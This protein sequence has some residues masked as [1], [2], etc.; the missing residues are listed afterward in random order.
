MPVGFNPRIQNWMNSSNA[1]GSGTGNE[2][3]AAALGQLGTGA[4]NAMSTL[5]LL[6]MFGMGGGQNTTPQVS[7]GLPFGGES[8]SAPIQGPVPYKTLPQQTIPRT[9]TFQR[10]LMAPPSGMN[11]PIGYGQPQ[12]VFQNIRPR[13]RAPAAVPNYATS[14]TF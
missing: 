4:G 10:G 5:P 12:G 13:R 8:A 14:E 7:G 6:R 11:Q 9:R 3:I 1:P 2:R